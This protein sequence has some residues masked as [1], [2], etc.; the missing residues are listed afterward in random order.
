MENNSCFPRIVCAVACLL[1][2]QCAS[3]HEPSRWLSDPDKVPMDPYGAWIEVKTDSGRVDGEFIAVSPDSVFVA[4]TSLQVMSRTR[5]V[6][7]RVVLYNSND[8]SGGL[9]LG[10]L[11]TISNG[12]LLII[13]APMWFIGG[14]IA[15]VSRSFDP[16]FDYP[17]R[18][19][20]E[21]A[22]YAR[23][24]RGI[25]SGIDRSGLKMKRVEKRE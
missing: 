9:I 16:V 15:T 7:A 6:S 11:L 12:L 23:F 8:V 10:P 20:E 21:L 25:P 18:P 3:S 1:F 4:N 17:K 5:I 24:P 19:F 2:E 22:R 14:T 13:T